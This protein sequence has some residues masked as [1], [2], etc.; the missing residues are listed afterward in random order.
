MELRSQFSKI[1]SIANKLEAQLNFQTLT[2]NW[3]GD[4]ETILAIKLSFETP[5]TFNQHQAGIK[6]SADIST[7]KKFSDDVICIINQPALKIFCYIA[8]TPSELELLSSQPK[9]IAGFIQAKSSKVL[10]LIAQECSLP[11]I[12]P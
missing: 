5:D 2:A 11:T 9:I 4:E 10:N 12:K 6:D 8:L 7:I 3:Y 1:T